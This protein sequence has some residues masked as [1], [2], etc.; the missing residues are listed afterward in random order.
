MVKDAETGQRGFLLTGR[1]EYLQP[2]VAANAGLLAEVNGLRPLLADNPA[3]LRRAETLRQLVVDKLAEL[4]E[5]IE[6]Q[7][8]G[9]EA[10]AMA[11]VGGDRGKG[12]MDQIR[13]A[14]ERDD[15][16]GADPARDAFSGPGGGAVPCRDRGLGRPRG[17]AA[18]GAHRRHDDGARDA[19]PGD[20]GLGCAPGRPRWCWPCRA[21]S[22]WRCSAHACCSS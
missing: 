15:D 1:E 14:G 22:G 18:A 19:A 10:E 12:L 3:Q 20:R 4:K 21:N 16:G 7:R 17:T 11:M 13:P 6:L 2:Y 9:R 5:T 8:G